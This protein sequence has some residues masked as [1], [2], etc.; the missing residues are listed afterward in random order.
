MI[1][2]FDFSKL[3]DSMYKLFKTM[4]KEDEN[5]KKE[6]YRAKKFKEEL[7]KIPNHPEAFKMLIDGIVSQSWY[8]SRIL[9]KPEYRQ[10]LDILLQKYGV[11]GLSTNEGREVFLKFV[12]KWAPLRIRDRVLQQINCLLDLLK[13]TSFRE[14]IEDMNRRGKIGKCSIGK[15]GLNDFLRYMG[16]WDRVPIDIHEMRFIIRT[17]IYLA[18]PKEKFDPLNRDHLGEA[19][20]TFAKRYLKGKTIADI[21]LGKSPGIIDIFIWNFCSKRRDPPSDYANICGI[22]PK[23]SKCPLNKNCLYNI[24]KGKLLT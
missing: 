18:H 5:V 15:K 6:I 1:I 16:Y 19:L 17:G 10:E 23:C 7:R 2:E 12:E 9:K 22:K 11:K 8:Y 13:E 20:K 14:V 3:A 21:D 4:Y 24:L